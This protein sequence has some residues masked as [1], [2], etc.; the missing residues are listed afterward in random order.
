MT[1]DPVTVARPPALLLLPLLALLAQRASAQSCAPTDAFGSWS[2]SQ[3]GVPG[4]SCSSCS[5]SNAAGFTLSCPPGYGVSGSAGG[6]C[7]YSKSCG[8][9]T[10]I[11]IC[12][13]CQS[14][15][16]SA[17][18][19]G[20]GTCGERARRA[21]SSRRRARAPAPRAPPAASRTRAARRRA[22]CARELVAAN[23]R[24]RLA[25]DVPLA[26]DAP[27]ISHQYHSLT[28]SLAP[29][30]S[31]RLFRLVLART[32]WLVRRSA[33]PARWARPRT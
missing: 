16:Y 2:G 11:G 25:L 20:S 9:N 4:V 31:P 13:S 6:T 28:R 12:T 14:C 33:R 27:N 23:S 15:G 24:R 7:T 21:P 3:P 19:S 26:R 10:V 8:K 32:R 22:S 30:S 18:F 17:S 1:I 29:P 5:G